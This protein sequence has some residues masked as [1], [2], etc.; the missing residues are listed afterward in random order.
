MEIT[1]NYTNSLDACETVLALKAEDNK[2]HFFKGIIKYENLNDFD[3]LKN[4]L[5]A[6]FLESSTN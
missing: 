2:L 3:A 6:Q 1:R 4:K 5:K